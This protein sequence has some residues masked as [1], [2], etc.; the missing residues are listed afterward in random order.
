[1]KYGEK[2]EYE[3]G[4]WCEVRGKSAEGPGRIQ[5]VHVIAGEPLH[6]IKM[7]NGTV[8]DGVEAFRMKP[9]DRPLPD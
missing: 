2:T 6:T 7:L 5:A 1:M 3:V 8:H 4:E 9:W